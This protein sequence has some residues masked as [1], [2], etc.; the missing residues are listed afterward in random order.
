[1]T[2]DPTVQQIIHGG[3]NQFKTL[4]ERI[5]DWLLYVLVVAFLVGAAILFTVRQT[6]NDTQASLRLFCPAWHDVATLPL[7]PT[8]VAGSTGV[9][10]VGDARIAYLGARCEHTRTGALPPADPRVTAY[11]KTK[12][13]S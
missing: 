4:R 13:H 11:L 5:E 7:S 1:M 3:P 2:D 8:A 10:L 6:A 9:A 12:A